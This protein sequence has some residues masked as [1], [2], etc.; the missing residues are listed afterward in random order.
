MYAELMGEPFPGIDKVNKESTLEYRKRALNRCWKRI[1]ETAKSVSPKC[2]IW[3]MCHTPD[4]PELNGSPVLQ[5]IDWFTNESD[6]GDVERMK[7]FAAKVGKQTRLSTT[8]ASWNGRDPVKTVR[9]AAAAEIDIGLY[10]FATP[11]QGSLLPPV[12]T[13]LAKPIESFKGRAKNIAIFARVYN[14]LALDYV[15]T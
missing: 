6:D 9:D 8:L 2:L 10:G 13:Y 15:S 4:H 3:L 7:Q 12:S 5:Q 1:Y 11:T 14:G